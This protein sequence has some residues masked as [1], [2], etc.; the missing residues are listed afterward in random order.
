[1]VKAFKL[2]APHEDGSMEHYLTASR[3]NLLEKREAELFPVLNRNPQAAV[4]A[5]TRLLEQMRVRPA[6]FFNFGLSIDEYGAFIHRHVWMRITREIYKT[7]M[8]N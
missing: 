5:S 8:F 1:M 3:F 2:A 4:A 6:D 7:K